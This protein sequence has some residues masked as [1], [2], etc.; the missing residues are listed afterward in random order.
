MAKFLYD[1]IMI[2][3]VPPDEI[4][5]VQ[6]DNGSSFVK[7]DVTKLATKMI[8]ANWVSSLPYNPPCQGKVHL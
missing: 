1:V 2:Q 8:K 4:L 7:A 5:I 6:S 3:G